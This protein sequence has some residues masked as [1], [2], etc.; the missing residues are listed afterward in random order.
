[1]RE[2]LYVDDAADALVF[3]L[4]NYSGESHVNV[5]T[6]EDI[7]IAD[8]AGTVVSVVGVAMRRSHSTPPN[9]TA[10]RAS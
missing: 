6:G 5:G 4:K 1:M 9:P 8:L 3:L 10:R 7:T 2:F